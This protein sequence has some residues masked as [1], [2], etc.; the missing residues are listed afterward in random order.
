MVPL[1][2][3]PW[4]IKSGFNRVD[5]VWV[6][7]KDPSDAI[8]F[9]LCFNFSGSV[10]GFPACLEIQH[11]VLDQLNPGFKYFSYLPILVL[12]RQATWDLN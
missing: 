9:K 10:D 5:C 2:F 8:P 3:P 6:L 4:K 11:H 12:Q 1:V 7:S